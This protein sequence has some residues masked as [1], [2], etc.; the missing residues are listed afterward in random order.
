MLGI[1]VIGQ[2]EGDRLGR[3]LTSVSRF[4]APVV[5]VDSGS[6]D[7]SVTLATQHGASV[8]KV[9]RSARFT[10]ARARN[11]GFQYLEEVMASNGQDFEYVQFV[12]GDCTLEHNW[13][14]TGVLYLSENPQCGAVAGALG[15][16]NRNLTIFHRLFDMEWQSISGPTTEVGGCALYRVQAFRDVAGFDPMIAAGEEPDLTLRLLR[17]RWCVMQLPVPMATHEAASH[18]WRAWWTRSERTGRSYME[19]V[20]KHWGTKERYR[21]REV[22]RIAFWAILLPVFIA[23]LFVSLVLDGLVGGLLQDLY[24]PIMVLSMGGALAYPI[25]IVKIA[26]ERHHRFQNAWGDALLYGFMTMIGKFAEGV[27]AL[28][29]LATRFC[30]RPLNARSKRV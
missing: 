27:G 18:S 11:E 6:T 14:D 13:I 19:G 12:D 8:V 24:L 7:D 30:V 15:E 1:V 5:Y 23:T 3:S 20:F 9:A 16:H 28:H 10:A 29:H 22:L 4:G 21:V 17:L 2:N 25:M 26:W